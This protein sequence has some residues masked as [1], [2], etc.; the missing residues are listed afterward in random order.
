[1]WLLE[2][3]FDNLFLTDP[4]ILGS[5][6]SSRLTAQK[7][8]S[9]ISGGFSVPVGE[10]PIDPDLL[11]ALRRNLRC[12]EGRAVADRLC[13]EQYEISSISFPNQSAIDESE[14]PGWRACHLMNCLRKGE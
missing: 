7:S 13:V 1:L 4:S 8:T 2:I 14:I 10:N 5:I 6:D 11:D 3:Y 9:A 12:S